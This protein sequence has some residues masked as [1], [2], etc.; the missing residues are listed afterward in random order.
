MEVHYRIHKGS[1]LV[2]VLSQMNSVVPPYPIS[3]LSIFI[4]S[5]HLSI[6]L[7]SGIF[8]S[9]FSTRILYASLLFPNR[10]KL[11]MQFLSVDELWYRV[12]SK[13]SLT[14]EPPSLKHAAAYWLASFKKIAEVYRRIMNVD[15]PVVVGIF[16][17]VYKIL[18]VWPHSGNDEIC[19]L[20]RP[21]HT[22]SPLADFSTLK[23]E[24]IRSSETSVNAR[25]TQRH[26]PED[27]T[28]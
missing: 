9:D 12:R 5:S 20:Q 10:H 26:I 21:V 11:H 3:L 19:S 6:R 8:S 27:G 24:A 22:G 15:F 13:I 25:S 1:T 17:V 14:K 4:V 28:L 16:L 18:S 7:P 2:T 23:M